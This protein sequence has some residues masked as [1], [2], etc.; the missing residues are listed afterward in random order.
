M[1]EQSVICPYCWE[2]ITLLLDLSAGDQSYVEDCFVCCAPILVN[3][4]V[5]DGELVDIAVDKE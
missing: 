4:T 3:Y 5:E 1:L 2:S